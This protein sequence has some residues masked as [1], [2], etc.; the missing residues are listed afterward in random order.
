MIAIWLSIG[1][2]LAVGAFGALVAARAGRLG[3]PLACLLLA[4]LACPALAVDQKIAVDPPRNA[5]GTV[6]S[7]LAGIWVYWAPQR[8]S[9]TD[10]GKGNVVWGPVVSVGPTNR[11]W[12]PVGVYT[13]TVSVASGPYATWAIAVASYGAESEPVVA[14]FRIGS[15]PA[16][17]TKKVP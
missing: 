4:L 5:D 2:F 13:T 15:V 12:M 9:W 8:L 11:V 17:R 1:A 7:D 14:N 16:V 6:L 3:G 10:D